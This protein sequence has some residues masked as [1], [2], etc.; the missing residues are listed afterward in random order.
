[1]TRPRSN[2]P[3]LHLHLGPTSIKDQAA[4][5]ASCLIDAAA[6]RR[7]FQQHPEL[8][9]RERPCSPREIAANGCP[10]GSTVLVIRGPEGSQIRMILDPDPERN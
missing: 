10:Q 7:W 9:K 5:E 2:K 4:S 3:D 8:N 6:D 1:M